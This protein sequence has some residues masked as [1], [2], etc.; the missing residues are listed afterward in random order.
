MRLTPFARGGIVRSVSWQSGRGRGRVR[1]LPERRAAARFGR[2]KPRVS[3]AG[4]GSSAWS[5]SMRDQSA[6]LPASGAF[7][8][9]FVVLLHQ[10]RFVAGVPVVGSQGAAV[11]FASHVLLQS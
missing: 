6:S 2:G 9:V 5:I 3:A 7:V 11:L 10:S 8:L 4:V 1:P